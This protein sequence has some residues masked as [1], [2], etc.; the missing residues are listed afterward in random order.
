[1]TLTPGTK[2]GPYEIVA[3]LGAGGMG[4]VY[5]AHDARLARDV[6]IKALPAVFSADP[7]RLARFEREAKLLASLSHPNI[8]GIH[9]VED[10]AGAR[11]LVLEF[12]DG[13]ALDARLQRA[14][15]PLAETLDIVQQIAAGIEAAHEA[16]VV[17]RDLK[18]ANVMIT[19]G[20]V[21]KVLDFGLARA[22]TGRAGE[23]DPGLSA[24]PT[25]TYAATAAGVI[26][27]T[28]AYMSPEQARGKSVDRRTDIW[29]FGCVLF[30]CLT[31]KRAF[32]GETVS[33]LVARILER[34]PDWALLPA[35]TP[36]RL[37][38][39]LRR[40][41]I[42]DAKLRQRDMGDVRL[43]LH[44]IANGEGAV[45]AAPAAAATPASPRTWQLLSAALAVVAIVAVVA[46]MR[47]PQASQGPV[48]LALLAPPGVRMGLSPYD[49]AVSP[50]GSRVVFVG[51]DSLAGP[52]LWV[53]TL[54]HD[55]ARPL[56]HT[57]N[58]QQ[59]FW[60]PDGQRVGY[61]AGGRLCTV[62]ITSG[63]VHA[64]ADAPLPRGG[65]WGKGAIVY[66][67]RSLGPLM[68]VAEEGGTP[69][70]VTRVDSTA[71]EVG[72]RFPSFLPDG[73]HFAYTAL[74]D[75]NQ[76]CFGSLHDMRV[77]RM[78][79]ANSGP[80]IAGPDMVIYQRADKVVAQRFDR[81][82]FERQGAPVEVAD[83][84]VVATNVDGAP[85]LSA[86]WTGT[87]VQRC[88]VDRPRRLAWF[89]RDGRMQGVIPVEEGAYGFGSVSADGRTAVVMHDGG[90]E[91]IFAV[92]LIDL[93]RGSEH[94]L[95][96]TG[97]SETP[98]FAPDGR[99]VV[100]SKNTDGTDQNLWTLT[101]DAPGS[102]HRSVNSKTRFLNPLAVAADGRTVLLR[103]Q[104]TDTQQDLSV[105]TLGQDGLRPFIA[106]RFNEP[107][108]T[109]S[110]DG[111]WSAYLS[112]E[113]GRFEVRVRAF[114]DATGPITE[115]SHGAWCAPNGENRIGKPRWSSD[116]REII[117]TAPDARTLMSVAVTPGDPPRF[118][119]PRA[120]MR[121]PDAVADVA[122]QPDLQRFLVALI[123]DE[124]GRSS[125][126]VIVDWKP[127][128][129]KG[130]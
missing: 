42:K 111:R 48:A 28:A 37:L 106:T 11:Y 67:P 53:R 66:Q 78:G 19:H 87:L 81:R 88:A 107:I 72:H 118:S 17:H 105:A 46:R 126:T 41:F 116:G 43:E 10:V 32:E 122:E 18:P 108:G 9:G 44:A 101:A 13:E 35:S 36:P 120:L 45:G 103:T 14:R 74:R 119:E 75:T 12:V 100:F 112:D 39:L 63:A 104:G 60:S 124:E 86:S 15:M 128:P 38:A 79:G 95:E 113:S 97:G 92:W 34:E 115:I 114:P 7:E 16:G 52:R 61:F 93:Q 125:A 21:V 64:I 23:S 65:S 69:V 27:G 51:A 2:L 6:A 99:T 94:P 102:E 89:G 82:T 47:A 76:L 127:S 70:A 29:S 90:Q 49:V 83:V 58:P 25:M 109:L 123:R 4:E 121:L 96:F 1:M 40:C 8:A 117:Y 3:P 110:P 80:T 20:G 22:G 54:S 73:E 62:D 129:K 84:R 68:S 50:D 130:H 26:L 77:H 57:E 31:G 24:S 91:M 30:E 55:D 56:E 71:R 85:L 98:I 5:R 59:P 33:D